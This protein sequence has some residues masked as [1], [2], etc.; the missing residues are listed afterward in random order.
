MEWR[1]GECYRL[2]TDELLALREPP[3][4]HGPDTL[5]VAYNC[6]AE[7]GCFMALHWPLPVHVLDLLIEYRQFANGRIYKEESRELIQVMAR[8]GLALKDPP[9]KEEMYRL[10]LTGGPFSSKQRQN[11]LDYNWTDI[12]MLQTLLPWLLERMPGNLELSLYHGRYTIP[13][14]LTMR[15]GIPVDGKLWHQF[16]KYREPIQLEVIQDH[17]VYKGTTFDLDRFAGWLKGIGLLELWI[18]ASRSR[19]H[20]TGLTSRGKTII[21]GREE[22]QGQLLA[23][24]EI[25]RKLDSIPEIHDLRLIRS[26]VEQLHEPSFSIREDHRNYYSI[27]PFRAETSRNSSKSCLLQAPSW[28]RGLIQPTPGRG[29]VYCDYSQQEYYI[30]GLLSGDPEMLRL[31]SEGDAYVTFGIMAG[32]MP[33]G[34]TKQSH[35]DEREIAK[36]VSLAVLYGQSTAAMALKLNISQ[37]RAEDLLHEHKRRFPRVWQWRK[38]QTAEAHMQGY[39]TTIQGWRLYTTGRTSRG[40]LYN[41]PV[42]GTGADV[43]RLAHILLFEAGYAACPLHDGFLLEGPEADLEEIAQRSVEIMTEAGR[44][45]LG[46]ATILRVGRPRI[47]RYPERFLED[48]GEEMW[49]LVVGIVD[50]LEGLKTPFGDN[51]TTPSD[52][53][54]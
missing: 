46:A 4:P 35:P 54:W 38:Q 42:Q 23:K 7:L 37:H 30:A 41:F 49:Q 5:F 2:W 31:Y 9:N 43:M 18:K 27:L 51:S 22:F 29:L 1:T 48:R 8:H 36:T 34:A 16:L 45:V 26:V 11:I 15:T 50:R 10:I 44:R 6:T 19:Q 17:P 40:T 24:D 3:W 39:A 14:A 21:D 20:P 32:I 33:S 47:I 28:M 52:L 25:F 53:R 12:V 13:A